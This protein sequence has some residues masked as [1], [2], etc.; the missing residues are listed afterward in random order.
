M[1]IGFIWV[2]ILNPKKYYS[3]HYGQQNHPSS[4]QFKQKRDQ[5]DITTNIL[6][7]YVSISKCHNKNYKNIDMTLKSPSTNNMSCTSTADVHKK[8]ADATL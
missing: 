5:S 2:C 8:P 6:T 7:L 3:F 4:K 1:Y